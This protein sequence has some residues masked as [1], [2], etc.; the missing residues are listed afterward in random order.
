VS[1]RDKLPHERLALI[2]LAALVVGAGTYATVRAS[3]QPAP[4]VFEGL[5]SP[6]QGFPAQDPGPKN[7]TSSEVIV[8]VAGAVN[9]PGVLRLPIDSRVNDAIRAEGGSTPD[10]DLD[11]I[12]LAA[13]L[14]DGTQVFIP[15][16]S[17]AGEAAMVAEPYKPG[18][19]G[20]SAAA[21]GG[22]LKDPPSTP[23]SLNSGTAA[24]LEALPGIGPATAKKILDYRKAHGGFKSVD[25]LSAIG[26]FGEKKLKKLRPY[27]RL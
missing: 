13:R 19:S 16:K 20:S 11:R 4:I 26:G 1:L 27:L 5:N 14:V 7:T 12:N 9:H 6:P 21:H 2:G 25:E 15:H 18:A 24:D 3:R 8:H 23:V 17:K 10:A 22:K